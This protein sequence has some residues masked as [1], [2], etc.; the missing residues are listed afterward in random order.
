MLRPFIGMC[1]LALLQST[2]VAAELTQVISPQQLSAAERLAITDSGR[3]FVI[4]VLPEDAEALH[5]VLAEIVP[6]ERG[7]AIQSYV[8]GNLE[9][10]VDGRV[11]GA[12]AGDPCVFSGMTRFHDVV[13]AACYAPDGRTS[14][15]AVDTQQDSVRAGYFSSCN[16][17][18]STLPCTQTRNVYAN[19]MAVDA[20]GRI[21]FTNMYAHLN[22]ADGQLVVDASGSGTLQQL[23]IEDSAESSTS[24]VFK[25]RPWFGSDILTDSF[26]PNGV[27]IEGSTL[28]Y[29]AGPNI[30][31]VEIS[32][33]GRAGAVRTYYAGPALSYI[34]DFA[35]EHGKL[36]MSQVLLT[37]AIVR[38]EPSLGG[39]IALPTGSEP[40][41]LSTA[42]SSVSQIPSGNALFPEAGQLF[43]SYFGGGVYLLHGL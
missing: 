7:Y 24:L 14:L 28:Y 9:G 30:N 23:T 20:A 39:I 25:R 16:D 8:R 31:R 22:L 12:P 5:G 38:A 21:Y 4:G 36:L 13:Y 35:V 32:P 42:P 26:V 15:I 29:A 11:S 19:G 2:P 3:V 37:Q 41:Q 10:T 6:A 33:D 1:A 40:L 17:E 27:Q 34:D 18:P 43:T